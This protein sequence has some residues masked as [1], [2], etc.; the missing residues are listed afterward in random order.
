MNRSV[1]LSGAKSH[2]N[3]SFAHV[4]NLRFLSMLETLSFKHFLCE[5]ME[6]KVMKQV[7]GAE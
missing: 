5:K 7:K 2:L 4:R 1:G 3:T 6:D